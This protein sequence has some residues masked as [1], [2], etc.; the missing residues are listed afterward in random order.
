MVSRLSASQIN[1]A[2]CQLMG[3]EHLQHHK[4][5]NEITLEINLE[6]LEKFDDFK[7]I[8]TKMFRESLQANSASAINYDIPESPYAKTQIALSFPLNNAV[9]FDK[10]V[11]DRELGTLMNL[12][13]RPLCEV[14]TEDYM[15]KMAKFLASKLEEQ[16]E[17]EKK[18]AEERRRLKKEEKEKRK[19]QKANKNAK[20]EEK[21]ESNE[22]SPADN[23]A[24]EV[25]AQERRELLFKEMRKVIDETHRYQGRKLKVRILGDGSE[26]YASALWTLTLIYKN[27]LLVEDGFTDAMRDVI[28]YEWYNKLPE[29]Q[30]AKI[31]PKK[32]IEL[33]YKSLRVSEYVVFPDSKSVIWYTVDGVQLG[34]G[35][36]GFGVDIDPPFKR[37]YAIGVKHVHAGK[38]D[39]HPSLQMYRAL[40]AH[41]GLKNV[42]SSVHYCPADNISPFSLDETSE[43]LAFINNAF[44]VFDMPLK[45]SSGELSGQ[46]LE[47]LVSKPENVDLDAIA[48]RLADLR[49]N[50]F[51][52]FDQFNND[53]VS[54]ITEPLV[55]M[56]NTQ[57]AKRRNKDA[58]YA[59]YTFIDKL[60]SS[61][62]TAVKL[63]RNY[64]L[65]IDRV[66]LPSDDEIK[67]LLTTNLFAYK[68]AD[69][70]Y[71]YENKSVG[72]IHGDCVLVSLVATEQGLDFA[73]IDVSDCI[74]IPYGAHKN[75]DVK[76]YDSKAF[77]DILDEE[78]PPLEEG[79]DKEWQEKNQERLAK[80]AAKE[81]N[82]RSNNKRRK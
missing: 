76:F 74:Q 50:D 58:Q 11:I 44:L 25:S 28:V 21:Q 37:N 35:F 17:E 6:T 8:S 45:L 61:D 9:D 78:N 66:I 49:D 15:P 55:E 80:L 32:D 70:D 33:L 7:Y 40:L 13:E 18:A 52:D 57:E 29:E 16:R 12:I 31:F 60:L 51:C 23:A 75:D 46:S 5:S 69:D 54:T 73:S 47:V 3:Y 64:P 19:A 67:L 38:L 39:E 22:A 41:E 10:I 48:A 42:V 68:D 82:K 36:E 56:K 53:I 72:I 2:L 27:L 4:D 24:P 79:W 14:F 63:E 62:I 65:N 77:L 34:D 1:R 81:D 59:K 30:K 71:Y 43:Q 26:Q 20:D